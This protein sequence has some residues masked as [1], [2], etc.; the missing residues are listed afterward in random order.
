MI[1]GVERTYDTL[2]TSTVIQSRLR[3]HESVIRSKDRRY[4]SWAG[5]TERIDCI[6][7]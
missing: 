6:Y 2:P 1:D 5:H 7:C 4:V 3:S